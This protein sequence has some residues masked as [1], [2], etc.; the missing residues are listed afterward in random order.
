MARASS[1]NMMMSDSK[2]KLLPSPGESV[3]TLI[4][5]HSCV[6]AATLR[7][8]LCFIH[9]LK[10]LLAQS[11]SQKKKKFYAASKCV[12]FY[13]VS[14]E[15]EALGMTWGVVR[16]KNKA[17]HVDIDWPSL[18]PSWFSFPDLTAMEMQ[19]S[20]NFKLC[21]IAF[22]NKSHGLR[23]SHTEHALLG[24]TAVLLP[25]VCFW[26]NISSDSLTWLYQFPVSSL[27]PAR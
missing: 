9:S 8:T 22:C 23:C 18:S 2:P 24:F 1:S 16:K 25:A 13:I 6:G 4:L 14:S 21:W 7:H 20:V 10:C 15:P 12:P 19:M 17:G 5:Q 27:V 11:S 3:V 26:V